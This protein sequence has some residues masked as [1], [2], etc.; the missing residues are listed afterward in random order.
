[1]KGAIMAGGL[2]TRLYPLTYATNKHLLPVYDKPMIFYPIDTLVSAGIDELIVAAGGP[3]AGDFLPVLRNATTA[4]R[5]NLVYAGQ[6]QEV[7]IAGTLSRCEEFIGGDD[8]TVIPSDNTTDAA[9]GLAARCAGSSWRAS[10]ATPAPSIASIWSIVTG[11]RRR[12][13]ASRDA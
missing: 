6:E 9:I 12:R 3:H 13:S 11:L 10:G 1:M 7:G 5:R 2:G 4:G 8:V